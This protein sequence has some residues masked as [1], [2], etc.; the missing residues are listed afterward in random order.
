MT[1][2]IVTLDPITTAATSSATKTILSRYGYTCTLLTLAP[3]DETPRRL[4]RE[5]EEHL[6]FVISGQV[7]VR[8]AGINTVLNPETALLIPA[9]REH[10]IAASPAGEARLLRIE[11]P[12]R[13][14]TPA[15]L[16]LVTMDR[17]KVTS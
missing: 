6:L 4:P 13:Q 1:P 11:T 15:T 3:G 7:T 17:E 12:A 8:S 2:E 5:V 9:G 16:E 14:P 10:S